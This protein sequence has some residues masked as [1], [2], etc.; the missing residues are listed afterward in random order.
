MNIVMA[1]VMGVL[2][3]YVL[4]EWRNPPTVET[5]Y[6]DREDEGSREIRAELWHLDNADGD[7]HGFAPSFKECLDC[8]CENPFLRGRGNDRTL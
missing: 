5:V 4:H 2:A 7:L 3:G 1:Y 8:R 6:V